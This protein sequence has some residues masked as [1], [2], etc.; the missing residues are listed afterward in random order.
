[1]TERI[2]GQNENVNIYEYCHE[3]VAICKE[4]NLEFDEIKE[5]VIIGI[6]HKEL[7]NYL[8]SRTH[9]D[10]D[11]LYKVILTYVRIGNCRGTR[12]QEK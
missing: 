11:D 2:H 7:A 5:Q 10:E 8:I 3:K 1:M 12:I 9:K 4:L 6:Y